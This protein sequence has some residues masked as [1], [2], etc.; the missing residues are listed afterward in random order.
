MNK[1]MNN[2]PIK[3]YEK[4]LKKLI[5]DIWD[6]AETAFDENKSSKAMVSYLRSEGFNVEENIADMETAYVGVYGSGYPVICI[7]A[8]YDALPGL[9][10]KCDVAEYMPIEGK[11]NGHGCGHQLLGSGSIGA[12]LL[13]RDYL[14]ES[15][16]SGTVKIVGCPAEEVGSGK[17]YLSRDGF[18]DD[19]DIALCW[20]PDNINIVATGSSLACM[21]SYFKFHG[22]SSHAA[23]APHLGRSALDA[24]ELMNVGTNYLREHIEPQERVHYAILNTGGTAP[25]V[26]QSEAESAYLVR[27]SSAPK[28]R[29]LYERVCKIAQG[30]AMMTETSFDIVFDE[31]CSDTIPNFVLEDVLSESFKEIGVPQYTEEEKQYL[32]KFKDT[33]PKENLDNYFVPE[34]IKDKNKFKKNMKE[35]PVCNYIIEHIHR[36]EVSASSGSTDVGDVSWVVPTAQIRTACFAYGV[37]AHSW[38]YVAQG[39]S[40]SAFKGTI[41]ASNV[42]ANA[43]IKLFENHK[44]IEKAKEEFNERL[45]G[46]TYECLIPKNVKPHIFR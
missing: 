1:F 26:I 2:N 10:Q 35:E 38:Q 21:Q 45:N 18:F 43:A 23:S 9:S 13:I 46:I 17:A 44:L 30:A 22:I 25:N 40:S 27:S 31:G 34:E 42:L 20:H 15:G 28:A 37:D 29:R 36:D 5:D 33:V 24:V 12:A 4:G 19:C 14:K 11:N 8:E 39:K 16:C 32:Q 6:F 7:L 41:F 3:K